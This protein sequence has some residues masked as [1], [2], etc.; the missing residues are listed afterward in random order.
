M[1]KCKHDCDKAFAVGHDLTSICLQHVMGFSE[2]LAGIE[3]WLYVLI[4]N[5]VRENTVRDVLPFK[6]GIGR[7]ATAV[8]KDTLPPG[9]ENLLQVYF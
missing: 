2:V 6:I 7:V 5:C 1:E 9:Q 3:G 8:C 4:N